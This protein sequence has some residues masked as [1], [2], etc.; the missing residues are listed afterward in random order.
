VNHSE[1]L[2]YWRLSGFYFFFFASLGAFLPYWGLYLQ[3]VGLSAVQIGGLMAVLQGSKLIAPNF[4]GWISDRYGQRVRLIRW[5]AGLALL[6]FA[7]VG[8]SEEFL[9]IALVMLLFGVF[10]NA[11]LPQFEAVTF[12]FLAGSQASYSRI[13]LWGSVG[14]VVTVL[15]LGSLLEHYPLRGLPMMVC[16]ILFGIWLVSLSVPE[17][18]PQN[19]TNPSAP[20]PLSEVF[21]RY[22]RLFA[23]FAVCLLLQASHGPYYVFFSIYLEQFSYSK[24]E[25]GLLWA[26]GVIAEIAVFYWMQSLVNRVTWQQVLLVSLSLTVLRW[27]LTGWMVE[28]LWVLL[29]SQLLHAASFGAFHVAAIHL[30][31]HYFRGSQQGRGQALYSSVSFGAGG[32]LG[33]LGSGLLWDAWGPQWLFTIAAG[34]SLVALI[35]VW[36]WSVAIDV[37]TVT[38]HDKDFSELE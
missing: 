18:I 2:P 35:L 21:G 19:Q 6:I 28:H 3:S 7:L 34:V 16:L 38:I 30:V 36:K 20:K 29:M 15:C 4:W 5:S 8:L 9:W 17:V 26:L 23:F 32:L 22:P 12:S 1:H 31:D 13:R 37:A 27:L 11:M 10:W 25:I 14:F 33:G 24:V